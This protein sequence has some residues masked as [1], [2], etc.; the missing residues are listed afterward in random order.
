MSFRK[1]GNRPSESYLSGDDYVNGITADQRIRLDTLLLVLDEMAPRWDSTYDPDPYFED[2]YEVDDWDDDMYDDPRLVRPY[3]PFD[4]EDDY[5]CT[6]E[7]YDAQER[8]SGPYLNMLQDSD[9]PCST[10]QHGSHLSHLCVHGALFDKSRKRY[11]LRPWNNGARP[12]KQ[13]QKRRYRSVRPETI[14]H[15]MPPV[16][17]D[18]RTDAFKAFDAYHDGDRSNELV[19]S[20]IEGVTNDHDFDNDSEYADFA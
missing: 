5:G 1:S 10:P 6:E 9:E 12:V 11:R 13:W 4:Y 14:R 15:Y 16:T 8:D 3:D 18:A 17:K 2:Y 19:V 20:V 7:D